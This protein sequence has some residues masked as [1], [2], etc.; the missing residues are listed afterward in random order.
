MLIL[1]LKQLRKSTKHKAKNYSPLALTKPLQLQVNV[2]SDISL[3]Q[4]FSTFSSHGTCK[5]LLKF[6]STHTNKYIFSDLTKNRYSFDSFTLD[7]YSCVGCCHWFFFFFFDNLRENRSV[8]LTKQSGISH[9]K[10]SCSTLIENC[11]SLPM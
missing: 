5:Q 11:C 3:Y 2:I 4:R 10:N 1:K 8:P 6:C 9:F 7:S